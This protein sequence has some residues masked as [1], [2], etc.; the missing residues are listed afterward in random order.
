MEDNVEISPIASTGLPLPSS[1][2]VVP[3]A[4]E[5]PS[6]LR[7][8]RVGFLLSIVQG[9]L[10]LAARLTAPPPGSEP[11]AALVPALAQL[12]SALLGIAAIV[13]YFM[14]I[15]RLIRVLG[16]QPG[17]ECEF[18]PAGV[19]WRQLVPFYGLYVLYKWTSDVEQYTDWRLG[20]T[21]AIGVQALIGV[22]V[23]SGMAW[24]LDVAWL[25]HVVVFCALAILYK[26]VRHALRTLPPDDGAS[27]RY[28]GSLGLR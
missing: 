13:Y 17:W 15:H 7:P 26:P 20:R 6:L 23:G 5:R 22:M 1:S 4:D 8:L 10:Y 14:C 3:A 11:A 24:W 28:D 2:F 12:A 27:P 25:G 9:A 18:T 21:S 16:R 19:V